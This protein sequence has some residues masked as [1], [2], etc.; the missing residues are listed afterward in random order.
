[1][2]TEP[3][4]VDE[5]NVSAFYFILAAIAVPGYVVVIARRRREG[6]P[7]SMALKWGLAVWSIALL[8]GLAG[9]ILHR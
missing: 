3:E 2:P 7:I 4:G 5:V 1:M 8:V 9:L 6:E